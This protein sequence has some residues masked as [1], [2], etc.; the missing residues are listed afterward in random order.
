V[1]RLDEATYPGIELMR[2]LHVNRENHLNS[3]S[4]VLTIIIYWKL[5][6]SLVIK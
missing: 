2:P 5:F 6:Y 1:Y 4:Q 3:L